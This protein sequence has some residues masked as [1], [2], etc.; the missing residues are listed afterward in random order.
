M[1]DTGMRS[2]ES[3]DRQFRFQAVGI[4]TNFPVLQQ[5]TDKF[6]TRT[7]TAGKRAVNV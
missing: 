1:M 6:L 4:I 2:E 7:D 3:P 5:L